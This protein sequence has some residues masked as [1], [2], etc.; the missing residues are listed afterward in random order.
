[1]YFRKS[2]IYSHKLDVQEANISVSQ[3]Y[4]IG[5]YFFGCSFANRWDPCSRSMGCGDRSIASKNTHQAVRD[6]CRK[7]K[8]DDQVPR[9]RARSEIQSTNPNTQSKR[10]SHRE[11]DEF[12]NVD[13]V[14][15]S[16]KPSQFEVQLHISEDNEAVIKMIMKGRDTCPEPTELR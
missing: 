6:H 9:S 10:D 2:N 12:S 5:S 15:T 11:V 4:R 13:H 14:V 8:V 3:F 1:M 16:A 7:E